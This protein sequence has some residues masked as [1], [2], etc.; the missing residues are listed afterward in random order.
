MMRAEVRAKKQNSHVRIKGRINSD[1]EGGAAHRRAHSE[2][3]IRKKLDRDAGVE[4]EPFE[5]HGNVERF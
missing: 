1:E 3:K 5:M 2:A 4:I